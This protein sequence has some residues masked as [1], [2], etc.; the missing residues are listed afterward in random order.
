MGSFSP[1][2]VVKLKTIKKLMWN[3]EKYRKNFNEMNKNEC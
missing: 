2:K 3:A 1:N